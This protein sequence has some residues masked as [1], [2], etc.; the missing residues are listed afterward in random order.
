MSSRLITK[1][2]SHPVAS[3]VAGDDRAAEAVI[4]ADSADMLASFNVAGKAAGRSIFEEAFT[5]EVHEK[6]LNGGR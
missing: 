1:L 5:A 6:I 4:E 2:R 3:S